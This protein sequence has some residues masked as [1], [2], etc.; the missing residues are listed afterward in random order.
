[1]EFKKDFYIKEL[2]KRGAIL[3]CHRCGS[4]SFSIIE[5][6]SYFTI[7]E[8]PMGVVLGGTT[9]PLILVACSNCGAI[10]PHAIG[11]FE[12]LDS[13]TEKQENDGK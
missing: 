4:K 10:T 9:I 2:E 12:N 6:Y 3:P 7:Q 5:Q 11:A 1:M 8:K 13:L